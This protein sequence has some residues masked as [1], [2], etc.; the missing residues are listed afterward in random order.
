MASAIYAEITYVVLIHMSQ[1]QTG[2]LPYITCKKSVF[3]P[4]M[5]TILMSHA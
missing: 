4:L 2:Q 3:E 5:G 1:G